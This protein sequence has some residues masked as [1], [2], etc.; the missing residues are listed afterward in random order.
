MEGI[1]SETFSKYDS[2]DYIKS[3]ADAVEYLVAC[4][5]EGGDDPAFLAHAL[6]VVARARNMSE[7]ARRA[8]LT[9]AGLYRALDKDGNPT[10]STVVG[11]LKALGCRLSVAPLNRDRAA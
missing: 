5:E 3:D 1:M 4:M 10:L 11:V 9:R 2:D 6:G 7:I 8:G